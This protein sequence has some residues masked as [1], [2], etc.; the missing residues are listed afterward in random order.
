MA[1][2]ALGNALISGGM[3]ALTGGDPLV[4][5]GTDPTFLSDAKLDINQP[6]LS[7]AS[8]VNIGSA[9]AYVSPVGIVAAGLGGSDVLTR[10]L[11]AASDWLQISPSASSFA[12]RYDNGLLF[13]TDNRM[14]LMTPS[15]PLAVLTSVNLTE[16]TS[17]YTDYETG[18]L[19]YARAGELYKWD[20]GSQKL[21]YLY[22]SKE[23][24]FPKPINLGACKVESDAGADYVGNTAVVPGGLGIN[25]SGIGGGP[26]PYLVTDPIVT[27]RLY[28]RTH[29]TDTYV[30]VHTQAVT[31]NE[32]FR[33]PSGY[34]TD[35]VYFEL[36][37]SA[38][39]HAVY[40]AESMQELK[41]VGV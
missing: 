30:L 13:A 11:F 12:T 35:S 28:A 4:F 25:E 14:Y 26:V 40:M 31:S 33:L 41:R 36:E 9:V 15:E 5:T 32:P 29:N 21:A 17:F 24:V 20:S 27:L 3:S 38:R 19:Y 34:M 22:R 37:G 7:S 10:P 39:V 16:V 2:G 6:C 23:F 18:E 8:V 1:A